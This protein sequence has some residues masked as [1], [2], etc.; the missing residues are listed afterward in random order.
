MPEDWLRRQAVQIA[1]QLPENPDD[2]IRVLD[3]AKSL[4]DGFLRPQETLSRL[5]GEVLTF[6]VSASSSSR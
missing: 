3:L 1:A 4:V 6:P 5:A 2:A